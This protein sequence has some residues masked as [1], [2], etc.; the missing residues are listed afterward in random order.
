MLEQNQTNSFIPYGAPPVGVTPQGFSQQSY[1]PQ[2]FSPQGFTQ[3]GYNPQSFSPQGFS[4]QSY[5]PQSFSPQGFSQQGYNPQS[6]SPQGF[7][8]QGLDFG[9]IAGQIAGQILPKLPGLIMSLLAANPAIGAQVRAQSATPFAGSPQGFAPQ[10]FAP[11][12]FA[13]QG[14][15]P[16]GFT[17]QGF[18][19]QGFAPQGF[20]PQGFAPQGFAPQGFTPQGVNPQGFDF[21]QILSQITSQIVPALPG[22]VMGLLSA[23]PAIGAQVRTE[24]ATPFA[25]GPS[26]VSP[27]GFNLGHLAQ[28][29]VGHVAPMLPGLI[30]SVLSTDPNVASQLRTAG[31][32]VQPFPNYASSSTP[33]GG[34]GFGT[35]GSVPGVGVSPQGFDLGH[36]AQQVSSQLLPA[37]PGLIASLLA[38]NPTIGSQPRPTTH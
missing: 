29:I 3:Q 16:Q 2:S 26:G 5:N 8:P 14:F 31:A 19:P 15:A 36:L 6:L 10:G 24:S 7:S 25:T 17:P 18:A 30:F 23:N 22:L 35:F 4:Q 28:Q 27:Q 12:G 11:Q 20:T 32:T 1:N 21:G 38:T 37:L 13:P 9:H 33:V 34:T